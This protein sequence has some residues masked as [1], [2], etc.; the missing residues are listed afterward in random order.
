MPE[1]GKIML[2]FTKWLCYY[3]RALKKC[4]FSSAG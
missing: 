3:N 1:A 4:A 2:A